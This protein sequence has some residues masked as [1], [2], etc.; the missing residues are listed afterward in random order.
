VS[1]P[2]TFTARKAA[3]ANNLLSPKNIEPNSQCRISVLIMHD[4][5]PQACVFYCPCSI[6]TFFSPLLF[7]SPFCFFLSSS[8]SCRSATTRP[9]GE[10]ACCLWQRKIFRMEKVSA[11]PLGKG[12]G[13][14]SPP[15]FALSELVCP[16]RE[17]K[18][19]F[20]C[21]SARHDVGAYFDLVLSQMERRHY[22]QKWREHWFVCFTYPKKVELDFEFS[23]T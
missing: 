3:A 14:G 13:K 1:S 6:I 10:C 9:K 4:N 5:H 21:L 23:G 12:T 18:G 7:L 17:R 15:L 11:L 8:C 19:S 22:C 20:W 16:K 2:L